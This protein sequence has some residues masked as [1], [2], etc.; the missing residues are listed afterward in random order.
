MVDEHD[1][2]ALISA[3]S[4]AFL[5]L[6]DGLVDSVRVLGARFGV[7][8]RDVGGSA[9]AL[10]KAA[11]RLRPTYTRPEPPVQPAPQLSLADDDARREA[12][13]LCS[14]GRSRA[15]RASTEPRDL[16]ER[17]GELG[18]GRVREMHRGSRRAQGL[19]GFEQL[20]HGNLARGLDSPGSARSASHAAA[21]S[22]T[23]VAV[24][25]RCAAI[26]RFDSAR[27][28]RWARRGAQVTPG[29]RSR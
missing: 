27:R 2:G 26:S 20:T 23:S 12:R 16:F 3:W 13:A 8:L 6:P 22:V 4:C 29:R 21:E 5:R 1:G 28:R 14:L 24:V 7:A 11:L 17:R 18:F 10:S 9:A 25:R 19:R 15:G